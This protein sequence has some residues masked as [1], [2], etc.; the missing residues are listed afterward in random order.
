MRALHCQQRGAYDTSFVS[1][2]H[3]QRSQSHSHRITP[4]PTPPQTMP[5]RKGTRKNPRVPGGKRAQAIPP[6]NQNSKK[7]VACC[8]DS[9]GSY[10][11]IFK[12]P[13]GGYEI[14]TIHER[15]VA[16]DVAIRYQPKSSSEF[17]PHFYL[18]LNLSIPPA[19][20]R[21][22]EKLLSIG[23]R[24]SSCLGCPYYHTEIGFE[25]PRNDLDRLVKELTPIAQD[26]NMGISIEC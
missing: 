11:C 6:N 13:N 24:L 14:K 19:A 10:L 15:D 18:E 4:H 2:S 21:F 17:K 26:F 3:S 20:E 9:D 16:C 25:M 23:E 7:L 12:H 22:M 5:C 8:C 1:Q